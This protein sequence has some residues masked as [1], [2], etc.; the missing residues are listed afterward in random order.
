MSESS[1]ENVQQTSSHATGKTSSEHVVTITRRD[2]DVR[3][4]ASEQ[5]E[6]F[7][8]KEMRRGSALNPLNWSRKIGLRVLE[9]YWR[10]RLVQQIEKSM[11]ENSNSYL[12][13]DL[14]KSSIK[15]SDL[16]KGTVE[17][18]EI[19]ASAKKEQEK[20]AG[21]AK[22]EE[23]R[24]KAEK[25]KQQGTLVEAQGQL[26]DMLV[27]E[28]LRPIVEGQITNEKEIQTKLSEF[29]KAH[30][31]DPQVQAIFGRDA[32]QY[33]K[34]ADYFA[35]DLIETGR[36]IKQEIAAH[37]FAIEQ[38]NE[39]VR[40]QLANTRWAAETEPTFNAV[41][42]AVAW[43]ER[44]RLTGVLLNPA[45]IGAA[46]SLAT[47]ATM[48][49]TGA[50]ARAMQ[51]AVPVAGLLPGAL[52]AAA[53]RNYDLKV[54]MAAHR[55]ER[56][57]NKQI[58]Q[59]AKRRE[60]LEKFA[61]STVSVKELINGGGTELITGTQRKALSELLKEDLSDGQA[62]SRA[63]VIRRIAEIKSRLDFSSQEKVDLITFEGKEQVE[64]GRLGL[65]KAIVEART[66]LLNAGMADA[67][68]EQFENNFKGECKQKFIQNKEQQDRAFQGYRLRQ[69]GKAAFFGG[70]AGLS[71]GIVSQEV[72]AE[73]GR[74]VHGASELPVI[75]ALFGK[76]QTAAEKAVHSVATLA[77]HPE[78][79]AP[80]ASI[81]TFKELY[82]N[83]GVLDAG[84]NLAITINTT[85]HSF[86]FVD[87][88]TNQ[89]IPTKFPMFADNNG[90][91][92]VM[93]DI[94]QLPNEIKDVVK[95]WDPKEL[96]SISI[97]EQIKEA[98]ASS[99]P[100][101][102]TQGNVKMDVLNNNATLT[103]NNGDI[104][105]K[106]KIDSQG[107]LLLEGTDKAK[108]TLVHDELTKQGFESPGV[109]DNS[110]QKPSELERITDILAKKEMQ[111]IHYDNFNATIDGANHQ[112]TVQDFKTGQNFTVPIS[113]SAELTFDG[114]KIPKEALPIVKERLEAVGFT[115]AETQIPGETKTIEVAGPDKT[116]TKDVLEHFRSR[117][118]LEKAQ[119]LFWHD[120]DTPTH[121][122]EQGQLVGADG[123][124]LQF[125]HHTLKDGS[126]DLDMSKMISKITPKGFENWDSTIDNQYNRVTND[127]IQNADG[128]R[129]YKNFEFLITPND[130]ADKT[131]EIIRIAVNSDGHLQLPKESLLS[132]FF[133]IKDGKV[134][135]LARFVEVAHVEYDA[136][137]NVTGK[138]ILATSVGKGM[139]N[140][141]TTIPTKELQTVVTPETNILKAIPSVEHPIAY[142]YTL[143]TKPPTAFDLT[144]PEMEEAPPLIPTP[145]VPRYP[146]ERLE[147]PLTRETPSYYGAYT[148]FWN[149][150]PATQEF[151]RNRRSEKLKNNPDA[152]LDAGAEISD[153][154]NRQTPE[155]R[156]QLE[157]YLAQ[158]D[159]QQPMDDA[160]EA[161][162]VIP[163]YSLGEGQIV[164]NALEQYLLQIDS[165]KN[166][167]AVDPAK[168]E[169]ILFLNYPKPQIDGIEQ[170][171][172]RSIQEG[173]EKR[174]KLDKPEP[175][176]TEEVV[177]QFMVRHPELKIRIMKQEFDQRP[178]W[179]KIIK[180]LYDAA[181][182]RS[183]KRVSPQKKDISI[184]TNDIDVVTLSPGYMRNILQT[185]QETTGKLDG[186]V[187]KIDMPNH[188]Y[189]KY[190]GFLAAMRLFQHLDVQIHHRKN[191]NVITQGRNTI[192]RASI[193]AAIGGVN[194]DT[195]AG[196]DTELGRMINHARNNAQT[197]KYA[198]R[199]WLHTDPRREIQM[200]IDG[201][202]LPYAWDRWAAMDVYGKTWDSRFNVPPQDPSRLDKDFLERE[203]YFETERW[204]LNPNS[205]EMEKA[206]S[207]LGLKP[208]D[209][210]IGKRL[211]KHPR[212]G[213]AEVETI[214]IDRIDGV[215][216][217]LKK[218][219]E[220]KRRETT[221]RKIVKA[222]SSQ[223]SPTTPPSAI[224][225]PPVPAAP[226][227]P[228][229]AP[230]ETLEATA[231]IS[232]PTPPSQPEKTPK[233]MVEQIN[234]VLSESPGSQA[235]FQ[236][237]PQAIAD[238]LKTIE[239]S[240]G[241]K[242]ADL[243]A[244]IQNGNLATVG[245]IS[246]GLAGSIKFDI[247]LANDISGL[248]VVSR[249]VNVPWTLVL[250]GKQK[251]IEDAL[252]NLN[253]VLFSQ[254][255][256][257]IDPL[258]QLN[259]IQIQ[260]NN[261]AFDFKRKTS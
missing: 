184:V 45:T 128:T 32:T 217:R 195:D 30:E 119:R 66:A 149:L 36:A 218:Y 121:L 114:S 229:P 77:G 139:D 131:R 123:K 93:G 208:R 168:F 12:E 100:T 98:V 186:M 143:E 35:S 161:V 199:A 104:L 87:K 187:G 164:K 150:S 29:V 147:L 124:E 106:G 170:K 247:T 28:V 90:H 72:L 33:G 192:L 177:K 162:I 95:A 58:P 91:V 38:L 158:S 156:Q 222:L 151:Y 146:L 92:Q 102:I 67:E 24:L 179:G 137:G 216:E 82:Q 116:A 61:Y 234:K 205:K 157:N 71:A 174:V 211:I 167:Q 22:I 138:T 10:Q 118:E 57:Y 163:V 75:G 110:V 257:K 245:T 85:D 142:H 23:T 231:P 201:I 136:Q 207:F 250:A 65:V 165:S 51:F 19:D 246:A 160:C 210:H 200:W 127:I 34:L 202:P 11:L 42:K 111:T 60:A 242:I 180:P 235:R 183:S 44:H 226:P 70:V 197:I 144:P 204:G 74:N 122:N 64:Q 125:Y 189:E 8:K 203:I 212:K 115:T 94:D 133:E 17:N 221:E 135:Q 239:L 260:G 251:Q 130:A 21:K 227:A 132:Q 188:G 53:R 176:D 256:A 228:S 40:I 237:E 175:Y 79:T 113:D 105:A 108:L 81:D 148:A 252:A 152:Q 76:G 84:N 155:Y 48:R 145:F 46:F 5:A 209:Y 253:T 172:G 240:E 206:L 249:K 4:G 2:V 86:G 63:N 181:L 244:V 3:K 13:L 109:V 224:T 20:E 89:M 215:V 126:V 83:G 31:T 49:A 154:L 196:A 190:P 169:L 134:V 230:T 220:E 14:A 50:S 117:G 68:I 166:K 37:H 52:F 173:A 80:M 140:I 73:I 54:D 6:E 241:I 159:M 255:N 120:N 232:E 171:I 26:R 259:T 261:L 101:E 18:I 243:I 193:Y 47:F 25:L 97:K 103:D 78:V 191:I 198:N 107:F 69:A 236:T 182:L 27:A 223:P 233:D 112:I 16:F 59:G 248:K 153:Y 96:P 238:Y 258:W 41:D 178:Q 254:I 9:D 88:A 219:V 185:M 56:A 225:P 39:N 7:L 141:I 55:R 1:T 43:A 214:I 62:T 213:E 129:T 194:T 15:A 99:N